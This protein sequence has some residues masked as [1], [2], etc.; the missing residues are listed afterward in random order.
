ML[1]TGPSTSRCCATLRTGVRLARQEMKRWLFFPLLRREGDCPGLDPGAVRGI[2]AG[3]RVTHSGM[4]RHPLGG[5]KVMIL[6][7]KTD[8]FSNPWNAGQRPIALLPL[9]ASPLQLPGQHDRSH[10][11]PTFSKASFPAHFMG[12]CFPWKS[13]TG[14]RTAPCPSNDRCRSL[15]GPLRECDLLQAGSPRGQ[16]RHLPNPSAGARIVPLAHE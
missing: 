5:V 16:A 7:W 9:H 1:R 10:T 14:C 3:E 12:F 8:S 15:A 2:L 13:A 11:A 4:L 6:S